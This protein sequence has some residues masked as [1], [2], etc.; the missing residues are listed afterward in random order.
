[1]TS[2]EKRNKQDLK[3]L[4]SSLKLCKKHLKNFAQ[5]LPDQDAYCLVYCLLA[6]TIDHLED[7][8]IGLKFDLKSAKEELKQN[9]EQPSN[10]AKIWCPIK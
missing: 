9:K 10:R 1:M 3:E 2:K 4:F 8:I 6:D 7:C 5:A